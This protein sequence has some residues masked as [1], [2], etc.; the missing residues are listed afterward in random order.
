VQGVKNWRKVGEKFFFWQYKDLS[1]ICPILDE[2]E[3]Q[4][5]TSEGRLRGMIQRWLNYEGH[6]PSWRRL[7]YSLDH[8]EEITAAD[9]IRGFAEPPPGESS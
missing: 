4:Y 6:E 8:G 1:L 3:C 2:I 9:P 5:A 7:I